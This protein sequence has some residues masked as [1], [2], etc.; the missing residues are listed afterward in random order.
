MLLRWKGS[1]LLGLLLGLGVVP[2]AAGHGEEDGLRPVPQ[3]RVFSC[4]GEQALEQAIARR[5]PRL[6]SAPA[7][8]SVSSFDRD[9]G[10]VAILFDTGNLVVSAFTHT[11]AI[12]QQFYQTHAD[13]FD[14]LAIFISSAYNVDVQIEAGFAFHRRVFSDVQGVG[15]DPIDRRVELGLENTT[16][17]RSILQMND[18]LEY[19]P[20]FDEPLPQF[21]GLVEGVEI[22]GQEMAHR[23]A[24][25]AEVPGEGMLGRQGSHWS[26]FMNTDASVME[27][28]RWIEE[29]NGFLST[30]GFETFSQL[31]QYLMGVLDADLVT[32][33]LFVIQ[34]PIQTGGRIPGSQPEVGVFLRGDRRD[35]TMAEIIAQMGPRVPDSSVA[36]NVFTLA[37]LLVVPDGAPVPPGDLDRLELFRRTF[38]AWFQQETDGLGSI[39]TSLPG[40]PVTA[41]FETEVFAGPAPLEVA[42]RDLSR[43]PV[44]GYLWE[45]GDGET[46]TEVD[47][48][49]VYTAPGFYRARLTV[50]GPYGAV[51]APQVH[52]VVAQY[53]VERVHD[54]FES[55]VPTW[56]PTQPDTATSGGWVLEDPVGSSRVGIPVQPELDATPDPGVL[57][58]LT[59]NASPG[60]PVGSNDVDGGVTSLLSEVYDLSGEVLPI[61]E[62]QLWFSNALGG[63][64]GSDLWEVQASNDGGATWVTLD[65]TRQ[66]GRQWRTRQ[67]RI[68]DAFIPTEEVRFRFVVGDEGLP[69][70][71][72]AAIDEVRLLSLVGFPDSDGDGLPDGA[73]N[74]PDDSNHTQQDD[75]VDGVGAACDCDEADPEAGISPGDSMLL[76]AHP[77][78]PNKLRWSPDPVADVYNVY[79]GI[80]AAGEHF[81][82]VQFCHDKDVESL[83]TIDSLQPEP[84]SWFFYL[85]SAQNAC[86]EAG[87]GTASDNTPRPLIAPCPPPIIPGG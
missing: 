35:L 4:P 25:F 38:V 16:R 15:I 11:N 65:R 28:N 71:V 45:F 79:K 20:R 66:G 62:Y 51:V 32:E 37:F 30:A 75:D 56:Q 78:D 10:Q 40:V 2:P 1:L 9:E 74:C 3:V 43:G 7:Q 22:L 41:D 58:W 84:G 57:C 73:D 70:L 67:V 82:Y 26:F 23:F 42:F 36:P 44:T 21:S 83:E 33:P 14:Q 29:G 19:L 24:S 76:Q 17:L 49:H 13:D 85:V 5:Y 48:V 87:L 53:L 72:E 68:T 60:D 86:G 59:G 18:L 39:D 61:L 27:G 8:E 12:A 50:Q 46:S 81:D 80:L 52:A 47:P 64:P 34:S 55:L 31:D 69:S 77:G 54:D 63:E 6:L